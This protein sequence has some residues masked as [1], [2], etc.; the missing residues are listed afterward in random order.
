MS[1]MNFIQF[2]DPYGAAKLWGYD[3]YHGKVTIMILLGEALF[4]SL[5]APT[6]LD[7]SYKESK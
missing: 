5:G 1:N 3:N 2:T 7:C 4:S 6:I